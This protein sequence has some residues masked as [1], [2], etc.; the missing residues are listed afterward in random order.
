MRE[1]SLL[2]AGA[3]AGLVL[4]FG[5]LVASQS[6]T[7]AAPTAPPGLIAPSSTTTGPADRA[8]P[9][10]VPATAGPPSRPGP[11]TVNGPA[12]STPYGPVQ[13][14]IT[15]SG[16]RITSVTAL[17]LPAGGRS[18]RISSRAA[19]ILGQ[20]TLTAQSAT[21]DA[22]SGAS[23]TSDGWRTSLQAA[24]DLARHS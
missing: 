18:S 3:V 10:S 5:G 7:R 20:E 11:V 2:V 22:V 21:I 15:V 9:P 16:D 23:Y 14:R 4:T 6:T 17:T 19:P 24:L 12:A 1:P 13:V 8:T